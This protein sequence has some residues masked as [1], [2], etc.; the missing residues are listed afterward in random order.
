ML[1]QRL[2]QV[3]SLRSLYYFVLALARLATDNS[4]QSARRCCR[5]FEARSDPYEYASPVEQDRLYRCVDMLRRARP[6]GS[7]GQTMEIGCAEGAFTELLTAH[8]TD[9]LAVDFVP[10]A[11]ER[12]RVRTDWP[13]SVRFAHWNLCKDEVPGTFDLIVMMD[14]V[15]TIFRPREARAAIAKIVAALRSGGYLLITDPRQSEVFERAW[16]ACWML[17]GGVRIVEHIAKND[18]LRAIETH[19]TATHAIAL[20]RKK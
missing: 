8:C 3:Q 9:L 5:D 18:G 4:A 13:S 17:R 7:F 2:G 11:L 12:T 14:V 10:I 19:T 15:S 1:R 20:F 6:A 16:W